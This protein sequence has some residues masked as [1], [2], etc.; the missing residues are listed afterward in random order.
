MEKSGAVDNRRDEKEK[1][2]ET[3][4]GGGCVS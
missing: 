3:T 2:K 4:H 1:E